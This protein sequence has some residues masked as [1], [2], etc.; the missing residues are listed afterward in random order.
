MVEFQGVRSECPGNN[1]YTEVS[2][3]LNSRGVEIWTW[4]FG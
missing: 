3:Y 2:A 4:T 1:E